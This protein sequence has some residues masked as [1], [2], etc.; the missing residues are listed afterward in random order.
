MNDHDGAIENIIGSAERYANKRVIEVLEML[1][2]DKL[3]FNLLDEE[4]RV[5]RV[6]NI[7]HRI[8]QLKQ[9]D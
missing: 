9:D 4:H 7:T 2:D 1:A 3:I 5:I 8:K 6:V